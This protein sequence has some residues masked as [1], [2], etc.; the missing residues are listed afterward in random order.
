VGIT[1][2]S[3]GTVEGTGRLRGIFAVFASSR[4][5]TP[6]T[7]TGSQF[8]ASTSKEAA[9]GT[10][11]D[12]ARYHFRCCE[13]GRELEAKPFLYVCPGCSGLQRPGGVTR[14]V[15]EVV[16]EELP[17][18]W[19]DAPV[20][21]PGF[22]TSFLPVDDPGLL[23]TLPVGGT[24]LMD[25][26]RLRQALDMPRLWL[27]DDSRN[28]SGSTKDRAS[29]LVV[30]K[31]LE[32]GIDTVATASTGNAATALA[33][34]GAA[35][36][37]RTTVFVP[38]SAPPAKLVQM[39]SYGAVVLPVDGSYDDAFE[40]S[41]A[42]CDRFG[43]LNRNTA[44]NPF[45]IEGKKTAALEVAAALAPETPD[46]VVV[47][48]GDGVI[49]AGLAKGF[50]D[51][52]T[53]GLIAR[54]PKLV[55]VQPAGS[56]AIATALRRGDAD[57]T[58]VLGASSVADSLTVDAPRNAILCLQAVRSSGGTAVVVPDEAILAAI[59][60]LARLTGVFAEP[61]AAASLAG[62]EAA[63]AEGSVARDDRVVLMVTGSGL[64]DVAAARQAVEVPEPI[65]ATV[66]AAV[67]RL[68]SAS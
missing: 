30:A 28:P 17:S 29:L 16:I 46:V 35:A 54:R 32:W 37:L 19:P 43:W 13:C 50:A 68:R 38:A 51:L 21:S 36:G 60:R 9:T 67:R 47:P 5:E 6:S 10:I 53:A 18:A 58:P 7:S 55:A 65:E 57:I 26:P 2:R 31:A 1:P 61:A 56:A 11:E 49:I 42:A 34:V 66:E 59:P 64:K 33:A 24:P 41:L 63:I 44:F 4:W 22:L 8:E 12:V 27:K 62:L 48:T 23:P 15:L 52:E 39:L 3:G 20:T 14:G 45:T 25:V 40:L